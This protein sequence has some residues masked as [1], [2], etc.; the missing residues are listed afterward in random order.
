MSDHEGNRLTSMTKLVLHNPESL[1]AI[2]NEIKVTMELIDR[3]RT[4]P[5]YG[6]CEVVV[7]VSTDKA[8]WSGISAINGNESV[9]HLHW[10]VGNEIAR[11]WDMYRRDS[12]VTTNLTTIQQLDLDSHIVSSDNELI[13]CVRKGYYSI[14]EAN[15]RA[16]HH[17][18]KPLPL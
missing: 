2:F 1:N 10:L 14:R 17:V 16:K 12:G 15:L 5:L 4:K 9:G 6:K 11:Q 18:F 7:S 3:E 13:S 8:S